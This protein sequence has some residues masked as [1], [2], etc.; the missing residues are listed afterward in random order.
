MKTIGLLRVIV[1][2]DFGLSTFC[3]RMCLGFAL[4]VGWGTSQARAEG[5]PVVFVPG[6]AGS[7]LVEPGPGGTSSPLWISPRM[8]NPGEI[9]KASLGPGG[10][11]LV[12]DDLLRVLKLR[13]SLDLTIDA[14]D[15]PTV[16]Q[17][18]RL[19]N[20][21]QMQYPVYGNFADW[22]KN[23]WLAG[24]ARW[25]E[26]P[27]DWRKGASEESARAINAKVDQ[28]LRESGQSQV[29]LLAHSLGGLVCRDYICRDEANAR[30]VRSLIAVGTPWLGA[31]KAARGL[32]WGYNF[33]LGGRVDPPDQKMVK[34]VYIYYRDGGKQQQADY[35]TLISLLEPDRTRRVARTFPCVYQQ[36]PTPEFMELYGLAGSRRTPTSVFL[37]E[38]P[39]DTIDSYRL[40]GRESKEI[41]GR[42]LYSETVVWRKTLLN[43]ESHGVRHVLIA[44]IGHPNTPSDLATDMR[45]A[46]EGKPEEL[47]PDRKVG[48]TDATLSAEAK[49]WEQRPDRQTDASLDWIIQ[50]KLSLKQMMDRMGESTTL[51]K[52]MIFGANKKKMDMLDVLDKFF[53][54]NPILRDFG[55]FNWQLLRQESLRQ[56]REEKNLPLYF[57]PYV[58]IDTDAWRRGYGEF[59]L[60]AWLRG[61]QPSRARWGEGGVP[62]LSATAGVQVRS[63]L[64]RNEGA[65]SGRLGKETVVDV[66]RLGRDE[67]G[68]FYEHS[69]MLD[70]PQVKKL[71]QARYDEVSQPQTQPQPR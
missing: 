49:K 9:D 6:T 69:C 23:Q 47:L 34:G 63:D 31:P 42:D 14:E 8:L 3:R 48:G 55:N 28:A 60:D 29:I 33:G 37:G 58:A 54:I 16:F 30:K 38:A 61:D 68:N 18:R 13:V 26:V 12:A 65:A 62:L 64:T 2:P 56:L 10:V 22:A 35:H 45:M 59:A 24:S 71:I 25:Y 44:G 4:L 52:E 40:I 46:R 17:T 32:R 21:H 67:K 5:L 11:K 43:G 51:L 57:D 41:L 66:V 1:L 53:A 70:D 19:L 15:D 39:E 7:R 50:E 27:Y 20:I 36:L